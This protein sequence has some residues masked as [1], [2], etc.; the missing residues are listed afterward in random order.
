[1][2]VSKKFLKSKP[3]CKVRFDLASER[4]SEETK[5]V[6][7]LG[8]FSNWEPIPM[9]KVKGAFTRTLDLETGSSYEF[10]YRFDGENWENDEAADAYTPN[11]ISGDNSVISL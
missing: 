5:T 2:A 10:R 11:G 6:E 7:L 1:M 4:V 3:V 8:S 9:R